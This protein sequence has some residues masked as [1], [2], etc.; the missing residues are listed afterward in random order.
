[1]GPVWYLIAA[2]CLSA[3]AAAQTLSSDPALK[4]GAP[5]DPHRPLAQELRSSAAPGLSVTIVGAIA[6]NGPMQPLDLG[7]AG[8]L[9]TGKQTMTVGVLETSLIDPKTTAAWPHPWGERPVLHAPV[10]TAAEL[11]KSGFDALLLSTGHALDWGM[12]GMR[13]TQD[14]LG[15][16][17][18]VHA[19]TGDTAAQASAASYLDHPVGGGRI[20]FVS[21][22]THF[23][24]TSEALDQQGSAPGRPGV[25]AI[26]LG[27]VRLVTPEQF[28]GLQIAV[29]RFKDRSAAECGDPKPA[30][31]LTVF[32]S[33]FRKAAEAGTTRYEIDEI[34]AQRF[35]KGIREGK[36]N[37]DMLIAAIH[38]E[39]LEDARADLPAAPAYLRTLAHA[40]L[41]AGADIVLVTGQPGLGPVELHPVRGGH[42]PIFYG[43]DRFLG[44]AGQEKSS[45]LVQVNM[46]EAGLNVDFHPLALDSVGTPRIA[47]QAAA[48]AAL[49]RVQALSEQYGTRIA[50]IPSGNTAIGRIRLVEGK[51]Q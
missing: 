47:D 5:V 21:A 40:A 41:D 29:C 1:M 35:L 51:S 44:L 34:Q 24:P 15:T 3:P 31:E 48:D 42:R 46:V 12:V 20:A 9:R 14:A 13:A 43:L 6:M 45:L 33:R 49:A 23:R 11:R 38:A 32:G 26:A 4:S 37:A 28:R 2:L 36:Q 18:I 50:V 19:G 7:V 30:D 16:A 17:G 22:A 25:S 10:E 27:I 39:Q 8:H